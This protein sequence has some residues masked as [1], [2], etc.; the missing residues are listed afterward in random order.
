MT[1]KGYLKYEPLGSTD[2]PRLAGAWLRTAFPGSPVPDPEFK[3][4]L[5]G[6]ACMNMNRPLRLCVQDSM[7]D[8]ASNARLACV[9]SPRWYSLPEDS[10]RTGVR[11][12]CSASGTKI[13]FVSI[14][15]NKRTE[16]TELAGRASLDSAP[17]DDI[18]RASDPVHGP[19]RFPWEEAESSQ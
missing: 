15:I 3:S 13:C 6:K 9:K 2:E 17:R 4:R 12:E 5:I 18:S 1:I 16:P 11:L 19:D 14:R 10:V 7:V 8:I